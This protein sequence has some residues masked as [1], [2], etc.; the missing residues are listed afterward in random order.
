MKEDEEKTSL[1]NE[2]LPQAC[3]ISTDEPSSTA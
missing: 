2:L 3:K 1:P